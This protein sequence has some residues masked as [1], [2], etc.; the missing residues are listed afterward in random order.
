MKGRRKQK[1]N[2]KVKVKIQFKKRFGFFLKEKLITKIN[3]KIK[4]T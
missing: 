3:D 4:R 2:A 1:K